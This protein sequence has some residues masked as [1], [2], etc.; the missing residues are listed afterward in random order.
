MKNPGNCSDSNVR[1]Y[2]EDFVSR[3]A[4]ELVPLR[5]PSEVCTLG[6]R[7]S[8]AIR[9]RGWSKRAS[10]LGHATGYHIQTGLQLGPPDTTL[11]FEN[12]PDDSLI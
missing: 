9:I 2:G 12:C 11:K 5:D 7:L 4:L 3:T 8:M 1:C 10:T 6:S